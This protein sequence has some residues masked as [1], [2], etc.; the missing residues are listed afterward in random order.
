MGVGDHLESVDQSVE[1]ES[2]GPFGRFESVDW[3]GL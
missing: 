2:A 3:H 1:V